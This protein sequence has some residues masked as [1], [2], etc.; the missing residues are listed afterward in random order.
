MGSNTMNGYCSMHPPPW[1]AMHEPI[2]WWS[3]QCRRDVEWV[4]RHSEDVR[5]HSECGTT[6][7]Q[8][9]PST[10]LAVSRVEV[11]EALITLDQVSRL[12]KDCAVLDWLTV[13]EKDSAQV[14]SSP[15]C[16][17]LCSI[18]NEAFLNTKSCHLIWYLV[19]CFPIPVIARLHMRTQRKVAVALIFWVG[20]L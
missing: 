10:A 8:I 14:I 18:L 19:L 4:K 17:A 12:E 16:L 15:R 9:L 5:R 13:S 2:K 6:Q 7:L 3:N 11:K 20:A 1:V